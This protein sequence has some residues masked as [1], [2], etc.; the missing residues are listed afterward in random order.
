MRLL[1]GRRSLPIVQTCLP[2]RL[3]STRR[4][5]VVLLPGSRTNILVSKQPRSHPCK[6][7]HE[8]EPLAEPKVSHWPQESAILERNFER[9]EVRK[10]VSRGTSRRNSYLGL[11]PGQ[12]PTCSSHPFWTLT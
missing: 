1:P 2:K 11:N 4:M 12:K 3:H 10:G 6:C 9:A 5:L 8:N 7:Y